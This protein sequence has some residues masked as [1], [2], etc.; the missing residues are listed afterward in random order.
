M[1]KFLNKIFGTNSDQDKVKVKS[2]D[3][4]DDEFY[5]YPENLAGLVIEYVKVNKEELE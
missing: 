1:K 2:I 5:K 4:L 3:K